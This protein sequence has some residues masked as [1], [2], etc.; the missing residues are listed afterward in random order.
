MMIFSETFFILE[1]FTWFFELINLFKR[2]FYCEILHGDL[3]KHELKIP[4]IKNEKLKIAKNF[5]GKTLK[6]WIILSGF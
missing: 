1:N 6:L 2:F 5:Q 3:Y 4:V